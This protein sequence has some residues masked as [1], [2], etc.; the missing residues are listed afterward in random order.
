MPKLTLPPAAPEVSPKPPLPPYHSPQNSWSLCLEELWLVWNRLKLQGTATTLLGDRDG[1]DTCHL[2]FCFEGRVLLLGFKSGTGNPM[3]IETGHCALVYHPQG[4]R[5][6]ACAGENGARAVEIQFSRRT[7]LRLIGPHGLRNPLIRSKHAKRPLE[8]L[9]KITPHMDRILHQTEDLLTGHD[10]DTLFLT[11]KAMELIWLFDRHFQQPRKHGVSRRD[12]E[13]VHAAQSIL[14]DRMTAPPP[15]EELAGQVGM[16]LSKLKQVFPRVCGRP[17][18]TYLRQARME[19]ALYLI[20]STDMSVIDVAYEV[21][22]ASPSQFARAFA[23]QFG[24][25]PSQARHTA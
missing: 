19:R 8:A 7:L 9:L 1:G 25:T 5:C 12:Q 23:D 4:C 16:S 21:G 3:D 13:A 22:Y 15:L 2:L 17:P 24:F 10:A 20:R 14:E 18:Y 11:S 6:M